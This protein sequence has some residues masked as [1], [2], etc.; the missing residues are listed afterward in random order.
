[1]SVKMAG[2]AAFLAAAKKELTQFEAQC[3]A[4]TKK[5]A[6]VLTECLFDQTPVW[7]GTA[8]RNY[9]WGVGAAPSGSEKAAVGSGDPGATGSM[10]APPAGEPRRP[11]NESA[12]LRDMENVL[13]A[14]NKL[15]PL[16]VT[17]FAQHFDLVENGSAPTPD[18]ARNPGGVMRLAEQSARAKLEHFE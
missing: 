17:N 11:A 10:G 14:V 18:R 13:R 7:E 8:V 1:M 5:A 16:F 12:A 15:T 3:V 9:A 2:V 6:Y 4:E